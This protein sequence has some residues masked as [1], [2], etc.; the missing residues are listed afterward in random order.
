M[1]LLLHIDISNVDDCLTSHCN[2]GHEGAMAI[3]T[4]LSACVSLKELFLSWN[5]IRGS[6]AI[7]IAQGL[8]H[9]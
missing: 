9:W 1:Y 7:A 4:A 5:H 8:H 6:G 3:G 2:I